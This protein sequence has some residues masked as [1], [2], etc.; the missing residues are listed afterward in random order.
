VRQAVQR[1][2]NAGV[3]VSIGPPTAD[4][5][6]ELRPV[7][8]AWLRGHFERGF[9]MNLDAL[10]ESRPDCL[11]AVARDELD[12]PVAF[13]RFAI[14]AGGR[15]LTLDVAPRRRDA[16]NGVVER[17]VVEMIE[18]GRANGAVEVSLNFAG[19]RRVFE[20]R[21]PLARVATLGIRL[22]D[23]WIE[24]WPLYRFCAKFRPAWRPRLLLVR[25]WPALVPVAVAALTAEF[26]H[27]AVD[28][29]ELSEAQVCGR[30][31]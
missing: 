7:L 16:P 2:H 6:E 26:A 20:S 15:I 25:S 30:V 10:L 22:F 29:P 27:R 1:T 14:C 21:S 11:I 12:Q 19:L 13:A 3:K 23:P 4:L 5:A 8:D 9:A 17:L 18:H 31:S 24:L 28:P